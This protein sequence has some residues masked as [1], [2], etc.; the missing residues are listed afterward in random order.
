MQVRPIRL[1]VG[2]RTNLLP[3]TTM[4][5]SVVLM[6]IARHLVLKEPFGIA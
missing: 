4:M 2:L 5:A 3:G 6:A 1:G